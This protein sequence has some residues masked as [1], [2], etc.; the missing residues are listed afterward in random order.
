MEFLQENRN[1]VILIAIIV[2]CYLV[3]QS[4]F[5]KYVLFTTKMRWMRL[6]NTSKII[7]SIIIIML[8]YYLWNKQ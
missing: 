3:I 8:V 6:S 2:I 4:P 5:G 7:I 1:I